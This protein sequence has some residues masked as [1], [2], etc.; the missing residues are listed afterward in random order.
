MA[1]NE[2]T[3]IKKDLETARK[4]Q[5]RILPDQLPENE[6]LSMVV[7]YYPLYDVGGDFY[8]FF[9]FN[10]GLGLVIADVTGHGVSAALDS[11]TVKIA[12]RNAKEYNKSPKELIGAMNRFLYKPSC[13]FCQ[14]RLSLY[15]L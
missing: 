9:E 11:S 14:C 2:L 13:S 6:N 5:M 3:T 7:S 15:R 1:K 4:I 8:D 12:F 10:D